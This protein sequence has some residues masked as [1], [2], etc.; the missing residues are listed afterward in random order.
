ML[1]LIGLFKKQVAGTVEMYYQY[2]HDYH[3]D[4]SK[5]EKTFN[6]KPASYSDGMKQL[7]ETLYKKR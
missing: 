7:A 3:F 5:F 4:S 6:F 1:Q 2:D